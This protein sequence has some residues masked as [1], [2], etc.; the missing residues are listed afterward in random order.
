MYQSEEFRKLMSENGKGRIIS[1]KTRA[2]MSVASKGRVPYNKGISLPIE[3]RHKM[4]KVKKGKPSPRRGI[5]MSEEQKR[6]ISESKKGTV[7]WNYGLKGWLAH[8]QTAEMKIKQSE[9][10]KRKR[11]GACNG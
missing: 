10:K 3:T 8:P 1:D 4:S 2:K 11:L 9:T 5:I 7:P 6:K